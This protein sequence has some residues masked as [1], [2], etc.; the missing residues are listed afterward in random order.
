MKHNINTTV[1]VRL[2]WELPGFNPWQKI[3]NP[4]WTVPQKFCQVREMIMIMSGK[5]QY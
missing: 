3:S 1:R 4:G 5:W 2:L